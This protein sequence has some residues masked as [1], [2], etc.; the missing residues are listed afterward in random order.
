M[1]KL[2]ET[3]LQTE[4]QT[5]LVPELIPKQEIASDNLNN[6]KVDTTIDP[7]TVGNYVYVSLCSCSI[8]CCIS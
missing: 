2:V 7:D 8:N 3:E 4:L 5:E 6:N 1:D